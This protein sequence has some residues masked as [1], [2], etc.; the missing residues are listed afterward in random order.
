DSA[1]RHESDPP[2]QFAPVGEE[3]VGA[4]Q[5]LLQPGNAKPRLG[6]RTIAEPGLG[7]PGVSPGYTD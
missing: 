4:N 1:C 2:P 6:C 3:T 7:V 5:R